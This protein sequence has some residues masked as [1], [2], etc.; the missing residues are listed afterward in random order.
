MAELNKNVN[1]IINRA[2]S[3]GETVTIL[4]HGKPIARIL[5]IDD[6]SSIE[7]SLRYLNAI[8][9]VEVPES[10]ESVIDLGRKRGL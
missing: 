4:K 6:R 2:H 3:S 8:E 1:S 10:V 9:P 5:P 7:G